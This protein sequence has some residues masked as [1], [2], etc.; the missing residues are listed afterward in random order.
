MLQGLAGW[1]EQSEQ[2]AEVHAGHIS[3][4]GVHFMLHPAFMQCTRDGGCV[5]HVMNTGSDRMLCLLDACTGM[6]NEGNTGLCM[7]SKQVVVAEDRLG[8]PEEVGMEGYS[9]GGEDIKKES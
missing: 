3:A 4:S 5:A 9:T 2:Q 8:H 1:T 7:R 6:R